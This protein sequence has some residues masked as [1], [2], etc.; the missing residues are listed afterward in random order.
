MIEKETKKYKRIWSMPDYA[1]WSPG[2]DEHL[3]FFHEVRPED[4]TS[5]IDYGCGQGKSVDF[6]KR[7]GFE[8]KGV[9]LVKLHEDT[10]IAPLWELPAGLNSDYA[11]CCDVMEHLPGQYVAQSIEQI[12]DATVVAGYFRISTVPDEY[13]RMIGQ[14]LHLTVE[15]GNWWFSQFKKLWPQVRLVRQLDDHVILH[16]RR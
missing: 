4:G 5:I 1:K 12:R 3:P 11:F 13:G 14:Q 15:N 7:C 8:T 16:A 6:F 2:T 9:D 10:I